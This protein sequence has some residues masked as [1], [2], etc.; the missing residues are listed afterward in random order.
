MGP[1]NKA[2]GG[3]PAWFQDRTGIAMEFCDLQS[4]AE[5]DLGWCAL[6]PPAAIFPES[7]PN[8]FASEHFYYRAGNTLADAAQAFKAQLTIALGAG[9]ENRAVVEGRQETF[10][11]ARVFIPNLPLAGD[12]RIITP[13]TD[14]TYLDQRAG[15]NIIETTE[16]GLACVNTFECTLDA[17][18]GPFLLPAASAGGAEVPPMPALVT[19]SPGSDPFYDAL[20]AAGTVT[21]DPGTGKS[22]LADPKRVGAVTGSL[23]PDF[24]DSTGASRNHNTFR[25]E[26][27][28]PA[29]AHDGPV[30][31][32]I[33]G[34]A[35]F[36][37]NGRLMTGAMPSNL[38]ALRATY[39]ADALGNVTDLDVFVEAGDALQ[40]RLPGQPVVS[41]AAPAL[42][43]YDQACAGALG[44]DPVTGETVVNPP[45]YAAPTG[46]AH[47]LAE[48][49]KDFWG[50]SQPGGLPPPYVCVVDASARDA[51]GLVVPA[52]Y[53]QRVI[54][55]VTIASAAYN[56]PDSGTLTVTATSSDPTAVLTLSG[57]GPAPAAAPGVASGRS[58]GTG[59]ELAASTATVTGL[60]APPSMVH[61]ISSRG[62]EKLLDTITARGTATVIGTPVATGETAT[63][64]EDCS[65]TAAT[66]CAPGQSLVVDLLANDTVLLNGTVTDLRSVVAN[67][68]ATVTVSASTP[69]LGVGSIS[70]DGQLTYTPNPN[71]SGVETINYTVYGG[72][73]GLEPC[74]RGD[75]HHARQRRARGGQCRVQHGGGHLRH[76]Q[77]DRLGQR[78][79]RQRRREGCGDRLLAARAR[80]AAGAG[81]RRRSVHGDHV[82]QL[83]RDVPGQGRR[84]PAVREHGH[85]RSD[86]DRQREHR[87]HQEQLQA[88]QRGGSGQHAL[89]RERRQYHPQR[90]DDDDR[91]QRRRPAHRRGLALARRPFHPASWAPRSST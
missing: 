66:S 32:A 75:Q 22:Y 79:G 2:L 33:D 7:F 23:L 24:V 8:A 17:A 37:V 46:L 47:T 4:Q 50:Q 77:P 43:F 90:P 10:G 1:I 73:Q 36:S 65:P 31:Y 16:V 28:A 91:L 25:I 54:D 42:S 14:I 27:R 86:G 53:L 87:V 30:I 74:R 88:W 38:G 58:A 69:T 41:P 72:G 49:D 57:Y 12:Y 61:V 29:P 35:N 70:P 44:V 80:R 48:T 81:E 89:D 40:A 6:V 83:Q 60:L 26:V 34:E 71:A 64:F 63:M 59:V 52:Y 5:L 78:P 62:G 39:K 9:F 19:A 15:G 20:V 82:R 68:Q 13:Y 84:R 21:A 76:H 11:R 85:S 51:S 3:Y 55:E 45:P 67:N 18:V 56:G